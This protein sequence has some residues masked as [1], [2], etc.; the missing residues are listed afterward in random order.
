MSGE[1]LM[2]N[3]FPFLLSLYILWFVV[4]IANGPSENFTQFYS[5]S[6][7]NVVGCIL[8]KSHRDFELSILLSNGKNE[9]L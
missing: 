9:W 3:I 8:K 1:W 4:Q 7:F 6:R 2:K 5:E